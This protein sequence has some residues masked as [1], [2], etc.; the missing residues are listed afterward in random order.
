M[1]ALVKKPKSSYLLGGRMNQ[2][3]NEC[4]DQ[5][6]SHPTYRDGQTNQVT[7]ECLGKKI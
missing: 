3:T 1:N 6:L 7:D 2:A 4:L 5:N